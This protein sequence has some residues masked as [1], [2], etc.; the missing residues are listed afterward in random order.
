MFRQKALTL[1]ETLLVLSIVAI[2]LGLA[3]PGYRHY[4]QQWQRRQAVLRLY[5]ISH[6]LWIYYE[7]QHA[8]SGFS[9][10]TPA[11][12]AYDFSFITLKKDTFTVQAVPKFSDK[13]CGRLSID[14]KQQK[15]ISGHQS[16]TQCW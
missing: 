12:D 8:F 6:Q 15:S 11:S 5:R 3:Y 7:R 10:S 13:A 2:L 4:W 16:V 9:L 14:E 1:I